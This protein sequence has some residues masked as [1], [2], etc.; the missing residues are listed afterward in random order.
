MNQ[1]STQQKVVRTADTD[2]VVI[3][4]PSLQNI[5]VTEV[6]IS[7][8]VAKYHR[9]FAAHEIAA[10]LG[11][12]KAKALAVLHAF[13]G[14]DVTSVFAGRGKKTAW[15]TWAVF[16]KVTEAFLVLAE[17]QHTSLAM[18]WYYLKGLWCT[19]MIE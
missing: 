5:P 11:P 4:V 18:L 13:T 14:C 1:A 16:P 7:F 6:W 9:Y 8:V 15:D 10:N 12:Y 17:T 3:I 19:Y 2:V